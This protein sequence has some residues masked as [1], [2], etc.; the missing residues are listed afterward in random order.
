MNGA[1]IACI[2]RLASLAAPSVVR[3][4]ARGAAARPAR[5]LEARSEVAPDVG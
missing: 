2:A 5:G 4:R 1:Y 3:A